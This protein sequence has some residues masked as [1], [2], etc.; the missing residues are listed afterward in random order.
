MYEHVCGRV[1]CKGCKTYVGADH[2]CY[3]PSKPVKTPVDKLMFFDVE[4]DQSSGDHVVNFVVAQYFDGEEKIFE[5]NEALEQFCS[6]LFD[7]KHK[8]YTVLAHNLKGFDGQFILRWLLEKGHTPTV[9]PQGSKLMCIQFT[10]LQ[11]TFI[12]SFNFLPMA[13]SKLPKTFGLSEL[14]KG[15][16]PH[17]F[18][19]EA[20]Q[21]YVGALPAKE[22]YTPNT[23]SSADR[24]NFMQWYEQRQAE[25][26][27]F[28]KEILMYCR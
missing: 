7:P 16:F 22:H 2:L 20:N 21:H 12:D 6:F 5:G 19:T 1:M 24:A 15:Y 14:V 13:L 27:D 18:N 11:M 26:F 9:I 25:P 4:T 8:G 17:L 23:M 10:T 3:L 28:R